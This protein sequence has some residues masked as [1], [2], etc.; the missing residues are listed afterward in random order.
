MAWKK[1][2]WSLVLLR[3]GI[4]S[5]D[6][7]LLCNGQ[8]CLRWVEGYEQGWQG[9]WT[10]Q[11]MK[12]LLPQAEKMFSES[13]VDLFQLYDGLSTS[14]TAKWLFHAS[15]E[16]AVLESSVASATSQK[17]RCS[18]HTPPARFGNPGWGPADGVNREGVCPLCL[19]HFDSHDGVVW[20]RE[21]LNFIKIQCT[22]FPFC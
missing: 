19:G 4:A 7:R 20:S 15:S 22:N 16:T 5:K 12:K 21:F 14:K 13:D 2:F 6:L 17:R 1:W 3:A 8:V 9:I 18:A 11:W 10:M